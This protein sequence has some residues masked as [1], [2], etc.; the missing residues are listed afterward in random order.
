MRSEYYFIFHSLFFCCCF[1]N[2]YRVEY[3]VSEDM[4][5]YVRTKIDDIVNRFVNVERDGV[6]E[7][8]RQTSKVVT[9]EDSDECYDSSDEDEE[10]EQLSS[11]VST[12][13]LDKA[14]SD[15]DK[16]NDIFGEVDEEK[17]PVRDK[18]EAYGVLFDE[19]D[20]DKPHV[21]PLIF[22]SI[23]DKNNSSH[24]HHLP[25]DGEMKARRKDSYALFVDT[26]DDEND[27]DSSLSPTPSP[28][29]LPPPSLSHDYPKIGNYLI[30]E[31]IHKTNK[32]RK[33]R[34]TDSP[35]LPISHVLDKMET[36]G[37][38]FQ[39]EDDDMTLTTPR[40][41]TSQEMTQR[42]GYEYTYNLSSFM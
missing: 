2:Y 37:K 42:F 13:D 39:D 34:S 4:D 24:T 29:P 33:H 30:P 14:E 23:H 16:K 12:S 17:L 18:T 31:G 35:L 36:Y 8:R 20:E 38:L 41:R 10:S 15:E 40:L 26:D 32:N 27:E 19:E 21:P 11:L 7:Q 5:K 9:E 1:K 22:N 3:R 28:S 6:G 25:P